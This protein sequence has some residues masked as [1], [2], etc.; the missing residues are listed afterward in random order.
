MSPF[1]DQH[2]Y[3]PLFDLPAQGNAPVI[4]ESITPYEFEDVVLIRA[5]GSDGAEGI[6]TCNFR[7][8]LLLP[9]LKE[10]VIPAFL[11]KDARELESLVNEV[12]VFRANYKYQGTPLWNC[13]SY[14]EA[15]IW[16]LLG[17]VWGKSVSDLI[18]GA[19]REKI[20]IYLSCMRRDNSAEE[21]VEM[22]KRRLDKTGAKAV[23]F[24]IG[25][26]MRNNEDSIPG[27]TD[28]L[29]PMAREVLGDDITLYVDANSSYDHKKAIEIGRVLE[30]LDYGWF[31][32]PCAFEQY[33]ETKAVA[34]A[35][36]IT[37]AGGEQDCNMGHFRVMIRDHVVDLVQP[38]LM[39]NGG[40]IRALRVADLARQYGI[41]I[42]PHSPKH[43]P[44]LATLLHFA[45][46][47]RHTG[48][49]MEYPVVP[50]EFSDWYRPHFA[51]EPGGF[52]SAP[53]GPGLGVEYDAEIWSRAKKL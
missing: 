24:K 53:Q 42:T 25:G 38:D 16:D 9:M 52:V 35:L 31:E 21:E 36:D 2:Y 26:R 51:V 22:L 20:P 49:Y 23:K 15:A 11:G 3:P 4:I 40:L 32:E 18:G 44:E 48:P 14:V 50:V 8:K 39:Y 27:R 43:N 6:G 17:R 37:V 1:S 47:V 46:T 10:L 12:Y 41:P 30:D 28:A 5:R 29:L 19:W 34:D 7:A 13:V 33:E 45:A